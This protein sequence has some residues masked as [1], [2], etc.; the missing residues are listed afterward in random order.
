MS[1]PAVTPTT[2]PQASALASNNALNA[3]LTNVIPL[4]RLSN[5][6][7]IVGNLLTDLPTNIHLPAAF[8]AGGVA[9]GGANG[10]AALAAAERDTWASRRQQQRRRREPSRGRTEAVCAAPHGAATPGG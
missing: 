2:Q 8:N 5:L 3:G 6:E 9:A 10:H 7:Q 1:F 4:D